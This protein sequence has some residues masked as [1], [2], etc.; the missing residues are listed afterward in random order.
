M[1]QSNFSEILSQYEFGN[2]N[3]NGY[4]L[5]DK[6][7]DWFRENA[8]NGTLKILLKDT[9]EDI[10][11]SNDL[12]KYDFVLLVIQAIGI[13]L[14]EEDIHFDLLFE[15]ADSITEDFTISADGDKK[16]WLL[17][18]LTDICIH[19]G[20]AIEWLAKRQPNLIPRVVEKIGKVQYESTGYGPQMYFATYKAVGLFWE[21]PQ[22]IAKRIIQ[23]VYLQHT[24]VRVI[25][26]TEELIGHLKEEGLYD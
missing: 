7:I 26:E 8:K 9:L 12:R 20:D 18:Q 3:G 24:D 21:M 15:I 5:F 6:Y 10:K 13:D 1:N 17:H 25:E 14:S 11:Y 23:E 2:K 4:S 16:S 19:H 22:E